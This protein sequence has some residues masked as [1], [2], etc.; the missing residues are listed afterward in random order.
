M[1]DAIAGFEAVLRAEAWARRLHAGQTR[2]GVAAEPYAVH[3][4]E[5]AA[6]T[7][8]FGGDDTAVAAAWLH[9]A[10]EDCPVT[11]AGIETEMG[12]AVAGLVDELT[13]P[14][15]LPRAERRRRQVAA[16]PHKSPRAALVK[17]ADKSSNLRALASSPP[18][19][20]SPDDALG[21]LRWGVAVVAALPDLPQPARAVV[22]DS[23]LGAWAAAVDGARAAAWARR[24]AAVGDAQLL[25]ELAADAAGRY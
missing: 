19:D 13:D 9:D 22:L 24:R 11:T 18:A 6:L 15:G 5:V 4:S 14:P 21:Y 20:W 3:L 25:A 2:K 12:A 10:V 23:A 7:R 16:A 1:S 17:A 8:A